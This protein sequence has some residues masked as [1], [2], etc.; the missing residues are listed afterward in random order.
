MNPIPELDNSLWYYMT[1]EEQLEY[2]KYDFI[3]MRKTLLLWEVE[4]R[5]DSLIN[6]C[7][8]GKFLD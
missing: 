6:F 1:E 4:A 5:L 8:T 7:N 2:I 3:H